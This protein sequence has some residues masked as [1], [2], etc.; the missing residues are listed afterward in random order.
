MVCTSFH[1]NA[2]LADNIDSPQIM[3]IHRGCAGVPKGSTEALLVALQELQAEA[4]ALTRDA[5]QLARDAVAFEQ[6]ELKLKQL[7]PLQVP[8]DSLNS[9]PFSTWQTLLCAVTHVRSV[10]GQWTD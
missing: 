4:E 1:A 10:C 7:P 2:Y 8:S 6:P 3:L 5:E 9:V